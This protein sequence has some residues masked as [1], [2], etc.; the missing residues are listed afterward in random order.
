MSISRIRA[1]SLQWKK[2]SGSRGKLAALWIGAVIGILLLCYL[3]LSI[4][5]QHH[6][7]FRTT[8]NG[9]GVS[10]A[11]EERVKEK[12]TEQIDSYTLQLKERG[13]TQESIAGLDIAMRPVFDD[14]IAR[15]LE[16]QN[17]FA[18]PYYLFHPQAFEAP[19]MVEYDDAALEIIIQ[20]LDCMDDGSWTESEDARI[21]EYTKDG[22]GIAKAVYGTRLDVEATGEKLRDAIGG[23]EPE[24]DME[25]A[26]CYVEP[27][28]T[29]EDDIFRDALE[30][31]N[32]YTG[33]AITYEGLEEPEILDGETISQWLAVDGEYHVVVDSDAMGEYVKTLARKYNTIFGSRP[34]DTSY[35]QTITIYGG[36]YGWWV[37]NAAEKEMILKDMEIGEDVSREPVY[38][39]TANSHEEQDYGDT[40]V[41]INLT[42]QHL[43]FYVDGELVV[44]SD[45]VSGNVA[46]LHGTPT[47]SFRLTYKTKDATLRGEDYESAVSFWMPFNGDVGMHDAS[48][49]STFGGNIYKTGGS[50][51]C[52]NLP[53][54]AAKVIYEH[55]EAGYPVLVYELPGTEPPVS[56]PA[57][58]PSAPAQEPDTPQA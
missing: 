13:G 44:E 9:V 1:M 16:G 55:I 47:G 7:A 36:N 41:E 4:Y 46:K 43:F 12:I 25:A 21:L 39:Q 19:T 51:G 57:Q 2:G 54:S 30:T 24:L 42:A 35:G 52:I 14:T 40:Y 18:W 33:F 34:L 38:I 31:L 29:E 53:Y 15:W 49:R 11:S 45:F 23:L 28:V 48:W 58:T 50:H 56:Q 17:G 37:D 20:G 8:V 3:G 26:G 10:G 27:A 22:Y 6:F 32:R 5:F